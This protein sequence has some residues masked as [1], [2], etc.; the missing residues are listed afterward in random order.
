MLLEC[1]WLR[2]EGTFM[3]FIGAFKSAFSGRKRSVP[4]R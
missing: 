2:F 4:V 3:P 1:T